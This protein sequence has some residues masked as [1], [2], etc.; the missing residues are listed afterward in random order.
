MTDCITTFFSAWGDLPPES[1]ADKLTAA[2]GPQFT[3]ADP[4]TPDV[5]TG[6]AA[7]LEYVAQFTAHMPDGEARV[8]ATSQ[9]ASCTRVTV[10][11]LSNGTHMMRGQYF[12]DLDTAG[13]I[14]RM[15][16]FIGLGE[17]K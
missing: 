16:G 9:T 1:R 10:D 7:F 13:K 14:T 15:I 2:L 6:Q 11:F 17:P 12:A 3:Y 5:V 8:V 4:N